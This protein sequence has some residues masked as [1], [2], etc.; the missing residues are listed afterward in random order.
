MLKFQFLMIF[1][2]LKCIRAQS[3]VCYM[4]D[5]YPFK[6]CQFILKMH[7]VPR[8]KSDQMSA[9]YIIVP[10][11]MLTCSLVFKN[12]QAYAKILELFC[13]I[14]LGSPT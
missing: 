2:L 3:V 5:V 14:H 13:L 12:S 1:H 6:L 10:L 8:N 4:V 9:V 7:I 11:Q